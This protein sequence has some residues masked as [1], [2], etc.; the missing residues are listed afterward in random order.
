MD[1]VAFQA[2]HPNVLCPV[3]S[4][5]S[6][7]LLLI[8][9]FTT[10]R[11][12][13][14]FFLFHLPPPSNSSASFFSHLMPCLCFVFVFVSCFLNVLPSVCISNKAPVC[15]CDNPRS[16]HVA[17]IYFEICCLFIYFPFSTPS[18]ACVAGDVKGGDYGRLF[19]LAT[20]S[21]Q[22]KSND[23][24]LKMHSLGLFSFVLPLWRYYKYWILI[25]PDLAGPHRP[26]AIPGLCSSLQPL[27]LSLPSFVS[28]LNTWSPPSQPKRIRLTLEEFTMSFW[29]GW[30]LASPK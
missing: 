1:L 16:T 2:F 11:S 8:D 10:D 19:P 7:M 4:P 5:Y 26:S 3:R 17:G 24:W 12:P 30:A 23:W 20:H 9:Y 15:E 6:A 25:N 14:S 28:K 18:E 29:T 27:Q 21:W 13:E 22:T